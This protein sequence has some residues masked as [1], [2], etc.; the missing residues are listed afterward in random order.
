MPGLINMHTHAAMSIFKGFSDDKSL[1]DWLRKLLV[2]L[3]L[4]RREGHL[5]GRRQ[6]RGTR[7][8]H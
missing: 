7:V 2:F 3:K 1:M 8:R 6:V 5:A 4:T